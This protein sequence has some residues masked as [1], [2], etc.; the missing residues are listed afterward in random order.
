MPFSP[1]DNRR[2]VNSDK[3]GQLRSDIVENC[4]GNPADV[5]KAPLFT[6]QCANL[7]DED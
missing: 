3:C 5:T 4:V 2:L 6:I 1:T 7:V